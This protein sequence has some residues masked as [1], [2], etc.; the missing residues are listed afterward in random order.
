M[1]MCLGVAWVHDGVTWCSF[2][3]AMM[4]GALSSVWGW[5][6]VG[7][8]LNALARKLLK[9]P[10]LRYVDDYFSVDRCAYLAAVWLLTSR[11]CCCLLGTQA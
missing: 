1:L 9:I 3:K 6:R 10:A 11:V 7:D 2:H 5:D 8:L 4:F